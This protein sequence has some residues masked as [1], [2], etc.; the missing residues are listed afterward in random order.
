MKLV[1]NKGQAVYMNYVMK[2]DKLRV[3]ILAAS[4]QVLKNRDKANVKSRTFAH[5]YQAEAWLKRNG[6]TQSV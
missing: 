2:H 6:Y 3:V 4:G 5:D 1:D